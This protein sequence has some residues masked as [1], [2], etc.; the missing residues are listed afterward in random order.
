PISPA[1]TALALQQDFISVAKRVFPGIVTI[2]TFVRV[3]ADNDAEVAPDTQTSQAKTDASQQGWIAAPGAAPDYP[4]FQPFRS[5]T[6][7]FVGDDG[8]LLAALQPLQVGPERLVDLIEIETSEGH[9]ILADVLGIEPTLQLAVLKGAVYQTWEK[10]SIQ[11]LVF[12][13]SEALEVG[14]MVLGFGDP[15]GPERFMGTGLLVAKPSRDCYQELMGATYMQA[16]MLVPAGAHGGPL[17]NLRGEVVGILSQLEIAGIGTRTTMGSAWALPSKILA[18]L[19]AS[20]QEANTMKSP[21]L[22]FSV[23]SRTEVATARGFKVFQGMSKPKHGIL[24]ENVFQPSPAQLAG[25]QPD[26]WLTDFNGVAIHAPV[27]FQR[28]LYLTG[29]GQKAVLTFTRAGESYTKEI[30]IERRPEAAKPR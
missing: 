4:G 5:G 23:M 27:V 10:S 29:V 25:V 21:W 8:A 14:S 19:F 12:G 11:P 6:G 26:D 7:F 18:G 13:D 17:V 15:S 30:V 1:N 24:I 3:A 2:R 28:Q 20:I 9:R 22:G 16:T